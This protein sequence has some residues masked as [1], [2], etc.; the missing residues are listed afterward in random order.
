MSAQGHDLRFAA[1]AAVAYVAVCGLYILGSDAWL[2]RAVGGDA[3]RFAR[4]STAKGLIFIGIMAVALF[5]LL[6]RKSSAVRRAAHRQAIAAAEANERLRL[7]VEGTPHFFFYILDQA[8]NVTYVSPTVEGITGRS[9][10]TWLGQHHWFA[11]ANPINDGARMRSRLTL[12]GE[13]SS[14]PIF[15]EVTHQDGHPVLLEAYESP[16]RRD[17]ELVG[18]QGIA[19]DV[20]QARAAEE[21]IAFQASL[22]DQVRNAVVATDQGGLVTFWNAFAETCTGWTAGEVMGRRLAEV[23]VPAGGR[24]LALRVIALL[25]RRGYWEGELE[26]RRK[27]GATVPLHV[28]GAL[29]RRADGDPAG[30]VAV[31][32][33]ITE[34]NRADK[35]R[36][37]LYSISQATNSAT[38]LEELLPKI[39]AIVGELM[40][41]KNFYIALADATS[42]RV[43]FPYFVDE[44]DPVPA[45]KP[46][47][48][49]LTEYV[50]RTGAPLLASP[51]VFA[52]LAASGEVESIGTPSIDWLGVPLKVRNRT[53]GVLVVQTYTEGVR[54]G[55][56]DLNLLQFVSAQVAAAIE[57]TRAEQALRESE[58]RYRRLVELS[59]DGIA[60]HCDG[61]VVF[62]NETGA[63]LLGY[64]AA[65]EVVGRNAIELVHPESRRM[66]M[67]RMRSALVD[68]RPQS[69]AEERFLR[70]DGSAIDVE[71]ASTP[72]TYRGRPA[73]QVVVRD[74]TE[75]KRLEEQLR[76]SQKLEAVGRLAGGVAHDINNLL[77]AVLSNIDV[78][79]RA[80]A[81][82]QHTS[83]VL[84]ELEVH[85]RRGSALTRQLLV[86]ARR[87]VSHPERNDVNEV[88]GG[89]TSLLR[90]L[91]R[92]NIRFTVEQHDGP[93]PVVADRGQ[94]EQVLVNL[95][96]NAADA[97]PNGGELV[98]A[99]GITGEEIWL[100]V[101]DSG[102][103]ITP[104]ARAR[105]F[106]P[107]Y[108][109]KDPG[110]GTGL[111]LAVVHGIITQYGGRIE[112]TS[113]A[114]EGSCF[115]VFLPL[116]QPLRGS[117]AAPA[118]EDVAVALGSGERI[119]LVEDEA[120]VRHGL[121][122]SL[123]T[124]GYAV[125]AVGSAEEAEQHPVSGFDV[126][127]TD[128]MLPGRHGLE[129][130]DRLLRRHPGLA[131]IVM[132][133]YAR[134]DSAFAGLS[135]PAVTY[136][137]KP[138]DLRTLSRALRHAVRVAQRGPVAEA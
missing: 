81:D 66:V 101:T 59:P 17:G 16:Y 106:E 122:E 26:A 51:D 12:A 25:R 111:G 13:F 1:L 131:V 123:R 32:T 63:R 31:A 65:S 125:T 126:V 99:T 72:F 127:V 105:I 54:Y 138:F 75:R 77:Q 9:A 46:P 29:L 93:L 48:R 86:F 20:T 57:R 67:E 128:L 80:P 4:L 58:E 133:G 112:V 62:A 42:G 83:D 76:Q 22:L 70:A 36:A 34:R 6:A 74:I 8:G 78:L 87:E 10:E 129:L 97:M 85:V 21:R 107:F 60:I 55:E 50:L 37:A 71:V 88:V 89:A 28:I 47:G 52:R 98:V 43:S 117:G 5:V 124:L 84:G 44:H 53:M 61:K 49:G 30:F 134:D 121:A 45:P 35:V 15:V 132:S 68:R 114:G 38:H 115:T 41:A 137:E 118:G 100:R 39:H 27:D 116:L 64:A 24:Q 19:H 104:E 33:D 135:S 40:P 120:A 82:P 69:M 3:E 96:V 90:R 108:T 14:E 11:T 18:V 95:V 119:L 94:L 7:L 92:E 73:V 102:V 109:T 136:L 91:V 79:R 2:L 113:E 23:L 56:A 130:T 103:G 110:Q